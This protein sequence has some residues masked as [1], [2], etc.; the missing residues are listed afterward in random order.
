[1]YCVSLEAIDIPASLK[2]CEKSPF[3]ES[4][5]KSVTFQDS[6]TE[7]PD[8]LF[9]KCANLNE[10]NLPESIEII[11]ERAFADCDSLY[12]VNVPKNIKVIEDYAFGYKMPEENSDDVPVSME[13]EFTI[14]GYM[15]TVANTYADKNGLNFEPVDYEFIVGDVDLNGVVNVFD[16]TLIQKYSSKI[17]T[18]N[19]YQL[20]NANT[21]NDDIINVFDATEI[22]RMIA[23]LV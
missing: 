16:A 7:I 21:N 22:Q 5:I 13:K 3:K 14:Y 8:G 4:G 15:D 11:G 23:G 9:E 18:L 2:V 19:E 17:T 10:V 1:M 20:K 6:M 12:S